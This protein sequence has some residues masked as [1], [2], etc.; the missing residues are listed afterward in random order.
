MQE[1]NPIDPADRELEE[2]LGALRPQGSSIS[3][4]EL[5]FRAGQRSMSARLWVWRG[6]TAAIAALAAIALGLFARPVAQPSPQIVYR[7]RVVERREL[8]PVATPL[9]G[10]SEESETRMS[11]GDF[12]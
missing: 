5:L 3:R 6:A 2:A 9:A 8:V 4:E 1:Q 10:P 12:R 11:P 7:D